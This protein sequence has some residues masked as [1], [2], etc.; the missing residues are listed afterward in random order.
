MARVQPGEAAGRRPPSGEEVI[1]VE[2]ITRVTDGFAYCVADCFADCFADRSCVAFK[3]HLKVLRRP[4]EPH[5]PDVRSATDGGDQVGR[6]THADQGLF[7]AG[8]I[9]VLGEP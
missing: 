4:G 8:V 7:R 9:S 3:T 1:A 6:P 2:R 5:T